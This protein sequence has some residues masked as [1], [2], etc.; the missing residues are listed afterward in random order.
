[1]AMPMSS[2]DS[3][4][5]RTKDWFASMSPPDAS[6][7][8]SCC[9]SCSSVM[10]ASVPKEHP[11][12]QSVP[13]CGLLAYPELYNSWGRL[14]ACMQKKVQEAWKTPQPHLQMCCIL[15]LF[16]EEDD[17][18]IM[19]L[20]HKKKGHIPKSGGNRLGDRRGGTQ[21][22]C[23]EWLLQLCSQSHKGIIWLFGEHK[24]LFVHVCRIESREGKGHLL[25]LSATKMYS[26]Y[27]ERLNLENTI[28]P[29]AGPFP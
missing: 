27:T 3:T 17:L 12:L 19:S 24:G 16:L 6:C 9:C 20:W 25:S 28:P 8:C 15:Q 26:L 23:F 5:S 21:W 13:H 10:L 22:R 1:M 2:G 4:N 18:N 14:S 7:S 11:C 29:Y